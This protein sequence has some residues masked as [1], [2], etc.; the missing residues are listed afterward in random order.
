[1]KKVLINPRYADSKS[2]QDYIEKLPAAFLEGGTLLWGGRNKIKSYAVEPA[3]A[4]GVIVVKRFKRPNAIQALGYLFRAHKARKA[5][6]NGMQLVERGVQTPVPV[7]CVEIKN[8]PWLQDAYYICGATSLPCI[9]GQTDRD[10]WNKELAS[11]FAKYAA[12]LHNRGVL[13]HDLNDTNVLYSA[14]A[15]GGYDFTVIDINRMA[16]Y[17]DGAQ[18][19]VKECIEN[20]T[21]FTGRIDLFEYVARVYAEARGLDVEPFAQKAVAQKLRHDRNWYRR[22]RFGRIFKRKKKN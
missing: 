22:K 19:P 18:I 4:D 13:H 14:A 17:A 20:L 21:R 1:M 6:L 11:A 7:A 15:D 16:F 8:G 5:Y 2:L 12:T 9:E 10:D 3:L